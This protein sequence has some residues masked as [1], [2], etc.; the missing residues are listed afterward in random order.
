MFWSSEL[1]KVLEKCFLKCWI[2]TLHKLKE[3]RTL[4]AYRLMI[5]KTN[6]RRRGIFY[7]L[8]EAWICI[9]MFLLS[10]FCFFIPGMKPSRWACS[11]YC[12]EML[13]DMTGKWQ[14]H[15]DSQKRLKYC[16]DLNVR[17][18]RQQSDSGV[19]QKSLLQR[20]NRHQDLNKFPPREQKDADTLSPPSWLHTAAVLLL[21][22]ESF[23]ELYKAL[24]EAILCY[25][26][27]KYTG[28]YCI[29]ERVCLLNSC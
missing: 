28:S 20:W 25:C 16:R 8:S 15:R 17:W 13:R 29:R 12:K 3:G 26:Q 21:L 5:K 19:C 24:G 14:I 18:A 10:S 9:I 27:L 4:A 22:P 23:W 1:F 2:V 6:K 7:T 11:I